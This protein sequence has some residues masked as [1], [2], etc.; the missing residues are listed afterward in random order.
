MKKYISIISN[1]EG[2]IEEYNNLFEE[3][4]Q[5]SEYLVAIEDELENI[6]FILNKKVDDDDKK[7]KYNNKLNPNRNDYDYINNK[8]IEIKKKIEKKEKEKEIKD[9]N[10]LKNEYIKKKK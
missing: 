4:E 1:P 9:I 2:T 5:L 3:Y 6:K 8:I 7:I 10:L